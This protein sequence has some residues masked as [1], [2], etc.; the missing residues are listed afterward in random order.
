MGRCS[1]LSA[2]NKGQ[3]GEDEQS[4]A[5]FREQRGHIKEAEGIAFDLGPSSSGDMV[6]FPPLPQS[7]QIAWS[8]QQDFGTQKK[9]RLE[10]LRG[11]YS[12][13]ATAFCISLGQ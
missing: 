1:T 2:E 3:R 11:S 4:V 13:K 7:L 8:S 10:I 12:K 9:L 5:H 6:L